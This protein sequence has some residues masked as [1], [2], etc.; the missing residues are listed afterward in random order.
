M[1]ERFLLSSEETEVQN[2]S[3]HVKIKR[4]L[5]FKLLSSQ[6][7]ATNL[8]FTLAYVP[9]PRKVRYISS[10]DIQGHFHHFKSRFDRHDLEICRR[11]R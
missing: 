7:S 11:K 5:T 3:R 4:Q 8:H 10:S 6:P 9:K 2:I 1:I